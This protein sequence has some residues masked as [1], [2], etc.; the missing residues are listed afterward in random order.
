MAKNKIISNDPP[1]VVIRAGIPILYEDADCF[2]INKP[3]GLVVHGNGKADEETLAD[4][5]LAKYPEIQS[6][7]EELVIGDKAVNRSG[8]VHRLD[9][10]TSGAL[11]IA[12]TEEA[13]QCF[14]KQFQN[15]TIEK[16]Y[17][18]FTY[19]AIASDEGVIDASIGRSTGDIRKWATGRGARGEM[20]EATTEYRVLARI[21]GD[22]D[23]TN[24]G[25]TEAG[26]YTYLEARPRTGRTHQIRVHL[27]HLN[28]P[29]VC[30]SLYAPNR[31]PAQAGDPVLGFKRLALHAR[32]L[33]LYGLTGKPISVTAPFPPDFEY[34]I[35][36]AQNG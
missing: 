32:S 4:I 13:Y 15:H 11:L 33:S 36:I 34:A 19:G 31:L 25:S 5:V 35:N 20:R 2:V 3:A 23:R 16:I 26:T 27:K 17:H 9:K 28:H 7:G 8:I 30:D 10:E 12:K 1:D 18:V 14:K 24:K 6:V 29:I 21:G 22:A